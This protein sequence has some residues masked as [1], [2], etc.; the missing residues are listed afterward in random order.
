MV[1]KNFISCNIRT[2]GDKRDTHD[3]HY[4]EYTVIQSMYFFY[5]TRKL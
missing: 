1:K 2:V 3:V 5:S 4:S